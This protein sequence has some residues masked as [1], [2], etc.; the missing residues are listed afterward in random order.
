V[1]LAGRRGACGSAEV[2]AACCHRLS[3]LS[4]PYALLSP[5]GGC[6]GHSLRVAPGRTTRGA[7]MLS[8]TPCSG[9]VARQRAALR[10]S[11]RRH[12][13]PTRCSASVRPPAL[14]CSPTPHATV[15]GRDA[16]HTR[17]FR[18]HAGERP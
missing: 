15:A 6:G 2:S 1:R 8:A 9:V 4:P 3:L 7:P 10:A 16:A 12:A 11:A 14:I 17:S 5:A 13:A 18:R